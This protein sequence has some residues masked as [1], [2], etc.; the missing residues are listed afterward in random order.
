MSE[1]KNSVGANGLLAQAL[2]HVK[3][4]LDAAAFLL[5]PAY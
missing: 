2:A 5:Q 1:R 3:I 4:I